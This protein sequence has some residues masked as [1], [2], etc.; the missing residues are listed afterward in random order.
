MQGLQVV[1]KTWI[2]LEGQTLERQ[3]LATVGCHCLVFG[4]LERTVRRSCVS[5]GGNHW[6]V[7]RTDHSTDDLIQEG[8]FEFVSTAVAPMCLTFTAGM[9]V[10]CGCDD[11]GDRWMADVI[12]VDGGAKDPKTPTLFLVADVDDPTV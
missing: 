8:H 4:G 9:T 10:I 2:C 7:D 5:T 6:M 11:S 3:L 1:R 12:Q